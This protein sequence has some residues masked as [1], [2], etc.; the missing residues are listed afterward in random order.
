MLAALLFAPCLVP[1][2]PAGCQRECAAGALAAHPRMAVGR[3][4]VLRL[5]GG[6]AAAASL[7]S[8]PSASPVIAEEPKQRGLSAAAL[9]KVVEE[10]LVERQFLVTGRLTRS[11]YDESCTFQD[12]IDTYTLSKWIKGTGAL[13]VASKSH[14]DIVPGSLKADDSEVRFR[15]AEDLCF[16]LPL[17]Q[18]IVPLTGTLIL[19]RD[20]ESGLIV[21]YKE[22]WDES[23]SDV[24]KKTRL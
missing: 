12:E 22:I 9:Q 18:P 10:D 21:K 3:R 23:L 17:V 1:A 11:I 7:F 19:T 8:G 5:G 4:D 14:V 6:V 2:P 16:N 13:F 15:F 20:P 24:L